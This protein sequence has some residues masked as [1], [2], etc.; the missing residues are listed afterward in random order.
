MRCWS[1]IVDPQAQSLLMSMMAT[2]LEQLLQ[3]G[4]GWGRM[5]IVDQSWIDTEGD[6]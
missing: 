2:L 5:E 6:W 4:I 1:R 3:H